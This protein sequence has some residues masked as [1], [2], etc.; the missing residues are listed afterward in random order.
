MILNFSLPNVEIFTFKKKDFFLVYNSERYDNTG[1]LLNQSSVRYG[2][3][4][5]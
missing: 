3:K 5:L 1:R 4:A 2:L